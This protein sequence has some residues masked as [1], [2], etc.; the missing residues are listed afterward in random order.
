MDYPSELTP[1]TAKAMYESIHE[2]F[3]PSVVQVVLGAVQETE[4]LLSKPWAK[5]LFT[6]SERVGK[7][8]AQACANTL[9]PCILECGGKSATV[10][11][12]TVPTAYLQ[13]VADRIVFSKF[14]NAGQVCVAPDTLFVHE[15]HV[16]PLKEALVRAIDAQFGK[17]PQSGE[18][19]RIVNK[20]NA[21]RLVDIIKEEE[22]YASKTSTL[23]KNEIVLGGSKACDIDQRYV[24]PTVV[25]NPSPESRLMKEEIFG[26][27]LPI[28]TFTKRD[29]AIELIRNMNKISGIPLFLYVFTTKDSVFQTYTD[30]C[31][32]GGA[33]RNDILIQLANTEQPLGGMGSSGYG[34]YFGKY[35]FDAFTHKYPVTW[36]PLGSFWDFGNLRCH[37]YE[38]WKTKVLED[39]L[40][41]LPKVPSYLG[42]HL[43]LCIPTLFLMSVALPPLVPSAIPASVKLWLASHLEDLAATLRDSNSS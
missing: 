29:E 10:V 35:S 27:V 24:A 33:V 43:L 13:N 30:K 39:Y 37:P 12:E 4:T 2:Y 17:N 15:H 14:F 7:L 8:V 18:M 41:Y 5:V 21:K 1:N 34:R 42:P 20:Q 25:L 36:R 22:S 9:T 40:L 23:D 26:P 16:T 32:S 6:G 11:D 38:G 31:R 28:R 3:D 19:A